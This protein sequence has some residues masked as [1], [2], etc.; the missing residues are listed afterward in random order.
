[1]SVCVCVCIYI[2]TYMILLFQSSL[3]TEGEVM[4]KLCF[5]CFCLEGSQV[6]LEDGPRQALSTDRGPTVS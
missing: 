3:F 2:H 5:N 4:N 1:M 6:F